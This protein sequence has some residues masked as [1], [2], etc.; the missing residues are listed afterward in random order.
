MNSLKL[1]K[2]TKTFENIEL[3]Q[4]V[5][6]N[7]PEYFLNVSGDVAVSGD[8]EDAFNALPPKFDLDKK[9]ILGIYFEGVLIGI[10]DCLIGF[11]VLEKAHIGLL[12][13][14]ETFQGRGFGKQSYE[15]LE[16]YLRSY[17]TLKIVRLSVVETNDIV[18]KFWRKLGFNLTGEVKPYS[19]KKIISNSLLMEK[20]LNS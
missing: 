19:N 10:I 16:K 5:F 1:I 13:L 18:L 7:A 3:V 11:P 6:E 4:K 9:H 8:S 20:K 14:D 17:P 15:E 2:L 12:I